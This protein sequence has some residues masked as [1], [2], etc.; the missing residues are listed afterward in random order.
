MSYGEGD[1]TLDN[2]SDHSST[3]IMSDRTTSLA[4]TRLRWCVLTKICDLR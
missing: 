2:G 3:Q 1:R 4:I